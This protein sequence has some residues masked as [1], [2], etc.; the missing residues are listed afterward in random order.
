[1]DMM[2]QLDAGGDQKEGECDSP[3]A[4]EA[5]AMVAAE[6][7]LVVDGDLNIVAEDEEEAATAV[8]QRVVAKRPQRQTRRNVIL[9]PAATTAMD[10]IVDNDSFEYKAEGSGDSSGT[11]TYRVVHVST[12][13]S[14]VGEEI[15]NISQIIHPTTNF[16]TG[17][18][19]SGVQAVLTSPINGQFY[20]IGSPQ[21]VFTGTNTRNIAPRNQSETVRGSTRRDE[22]R[23]ATHNEV[24]RRR[25]DKINNWI[26]KLGK[27]I[28]DCGNESGKQGQVSFEGQS[29][30]G[31]LA[32]ACDYIQDLRTINQRMSENVKES[33]RLAMQ[34][35]ALRQQNEELRRDKMALHN[36]LTQNGIVPVVEVSPVIVVEQDPLS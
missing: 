24:E 26:M 21:E 4:S 5:A 17:A 20:V 22:R 13:S 14:S 6:T 23:R 27:I 33:E 18:S 12:P 19:A 15:D 11:V 30:G 10:T 28:P 34:V 2:D 32:K 3:T 25:R 8:I 29:K 7:C 36:Q 31:I 16:T 35:E 9:Q 1:M